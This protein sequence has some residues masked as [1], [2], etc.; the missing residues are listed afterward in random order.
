MLLPNV[1]P[2]SSALIISIYDK[3]QNQVPKNNKKPTET[4]QQYLGWIYIVHCT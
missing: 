2:L 3:F 4:V 1:S